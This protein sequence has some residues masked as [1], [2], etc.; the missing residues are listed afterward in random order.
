[1]ASAKDFEESFDLYG[2][3]SPHGP[4]IIFNPIPHRGGYKVPAAFQM[5][6]AATGAYKSV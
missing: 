2:A 1:M 4:L 5:F 3:F 6:L